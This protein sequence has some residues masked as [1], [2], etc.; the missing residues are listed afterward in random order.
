MHMA[1][2]LISKEVGVAM[3]VVSI[4]TIAFVITNLKGKMTDKL[5]PL[6]GILGAFVFA[7]QMIN[8]SVPGVVGSSGHLVGSILLSS[9]LGPMPALI[10]ITSVLIIQSLFFADGG[11]L[12]LGCNIFNMGIIPCLIV[13]PLVFRPIIKARAG[14]L[15]LTLASVVSSMVALN[16]GAMFVV[17]MTTLSGMSMLPFNVFLGTMIGVHIPISIVEGVVTAAVLSYVYAQRKEII[18][19]IDFEA[20]TARSPKPVIIVLAI[21][22][23]VTAGVLSLYASS[24][25]DGLEWSIEKVARVELAE[26]VS[27]VHAWSQ[28]VQ[29]KLAFMPDYD[30]KEGVSTNINGTSAAGIVGSIIVLFVSVI[31]GFIIKISRQK[32][33]EDPIEE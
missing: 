11:I 15:N 27:A 18:E 25:P 12:A 23:F 33:R 26:G 8:F 22:A 10:V 16:L 3:S 14:I 29:D 13:Y 31:L 24:H 7:A 2:S 5:I 21:I 20:K 17:F 30:F 9:I 19:G 6:M 32:R 1:D 4:A 28:N